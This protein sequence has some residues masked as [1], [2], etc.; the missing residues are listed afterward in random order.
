MSIQKADGVQTELMHP[1]P[2]KV[3]EEKP[4]PDPT[5]ANLLDEDEERELA[6]LMG[7]D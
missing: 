1:P 2:P 4:S 5:D 7:E 3:V 6:E